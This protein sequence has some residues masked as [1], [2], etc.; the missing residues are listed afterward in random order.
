[1]RSR[2]SRADGRVSQA[3]ALLSVGDG[4]G[5]GIDGT[6]EDNEID[7]IIESR[8]EKKTLPLKRKYCS[9][10]TN[11]VD[12]LKIRLHRSDKHSHKSVRIPKVDKNEGSGGS[13]RNG[14]GI[15]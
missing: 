1:M 3:K 5:S 12:L 2:A 6:T 14:R 11:E 9:S 10:F 4:N 7:D 8:K 15:V 13:R